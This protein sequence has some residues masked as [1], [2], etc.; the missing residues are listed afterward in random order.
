MARLRGDEAAV[1]LPAVSNARHIALLGEAAE[2]LTRARAACAART[3]EEFVLTD[4]GAAA[5]ALQQITGARSSEAML[6][7]I[8]SRFCIGK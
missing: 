1:E 3:P 2:A 6:T 4:L 8:F 5:S 7:E